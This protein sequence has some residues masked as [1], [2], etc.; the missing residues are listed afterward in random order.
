MQHHTYIKP[1]SSSSQINGQCVGHE[2]ASS[3]MKC[4]YCKY[5]HTITVVVEHLTTWARYTHTIWMIGTTRYS[6]RITETWYFFNIMWTWWTIENHWDKYIITGCPDLNNVINYT[7]RTE[8]FVRAV[9]PSPLG[10]S[11]GGPYNDSTC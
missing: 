8:V 6:T 1:L 4:I 11:L 3:G 10:G 5:I 2:F 9:K 7:I